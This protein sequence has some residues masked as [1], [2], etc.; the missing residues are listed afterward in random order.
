MGYRNPFS[1]FTLR[2]MQPL[3]C[4]DCTR[5]ITVGYKNPF[6][7]LH[8]EDNAATDCTG[9]VT[10]EYREFLNYSTCTYMLFQLVNL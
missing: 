7:G 8:L 4:L 3:A 1:V 10:I 2:T 9:T 5:I 6:F